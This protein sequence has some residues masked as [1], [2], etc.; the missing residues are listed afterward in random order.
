MLL[1]GLLL[2]PVE[3]GFGLAQF[4][5][6]LQRL[7]VLVELIQGLDVVEEVRKDVRVLF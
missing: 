5:L 1:K 4:P 7:L 3:A 6:L 2:L